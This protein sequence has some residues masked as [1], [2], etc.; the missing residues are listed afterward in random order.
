MAEWVNVTRG[1]LAE[2]R[3]EVDGPLANN[4]LIVRRGNDEIRQAARVNI[5]REQG[6]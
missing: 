1:A 3:V 4:D 5:N 6:V 2:D